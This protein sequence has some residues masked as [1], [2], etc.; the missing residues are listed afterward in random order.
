MTE[1]ASVALQIAIVKRLKEDPATA[2]L[3]GDRIYDRVGPAP[4]FPYITI[5]EAHGIGGD[6]Q[7]GFANRDLHVDISIWSRAVGKVEAKR[8]G[9]A[10]QAALA[11]IDPQ[12]IGYRTPISAFVDEKYPTDPDGVT[13]HGVVSLR[14]YLQPTA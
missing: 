11:E 5:G 13:T 8:I 7:Y 14:F 12:A 1:P 2:A 6:I 9:G 4:T 3:V 10:V